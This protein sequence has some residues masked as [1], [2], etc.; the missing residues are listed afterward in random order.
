MKVAS[1]CSGSVPVHG[2]G[3]ASRWSTTDLFPRAGWLH[4]VDR[5]VAVP[6][7]DSLWFT[8]GANTPDASD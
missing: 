1:V 5:E 7:T 2:G 6:F 8:L 3:M 4:E